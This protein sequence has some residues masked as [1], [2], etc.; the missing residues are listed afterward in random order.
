MPAIFQVSENTAKDK[1]I[2][3]DEIGYTTWPCMSVRR[4]VAVD[5]ARMVQAHQVR[6]GGVEIINA[7]RMLHGDERQPCP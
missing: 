5:V 4:S 1:A 3:D 2:P 7:R 6:D